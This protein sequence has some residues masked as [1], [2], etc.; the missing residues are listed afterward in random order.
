MGSSVRGSRRL[1]VRRQLV[2]QPGHTSVLLMVARAESPDHPC[3]AHNVRAAGENE[4][5]DSIPG[6]AVVWGRKLATG[7]G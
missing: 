3:P 4:C 1:D 2:G 5:G 6:V 7:Y